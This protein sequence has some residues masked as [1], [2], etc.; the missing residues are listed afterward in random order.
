MVKLLRILLALAFI[1]L[2]ALRFSPCEIFAQDK[3]IAIVNTDVITQKDLNDFINFMRMQ[4][5]RD[6]KQ[7]DVEK[8]I[9]GMKLD[10]LTRLIEDR[11]IL[12][13]A[14]KEG[15][16]VDEARVKA[17]LDEIRQHYATDADFQK[18]LVRQ[19]LV[20]SDLES[21]IREQLLM[22]YIVELKIRDKVIVRPD[23]VTQLYNSNTKDFISPEER[24]L[25]VIALER[26]DL[27]K[28]FSFDYRT[29]KKLEELATR[30]PVIVNKMIISRE[31]GLRKEIADRV[32]S[33]NIGE[34]SDALKIEDKYYVFKLENI[35]PARQKTLAESQDQIHSFLFQRKM[36]ERLA[37][38]IDELKSK[39]YIK[40]LQN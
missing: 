23:E 40:I 17:R 11:L 1:A 2:C 15:I 22:Y 34:I 10:L 33:L 18:D 28:A 24:E 31:E 12:Q 14:K 30:Y 7:Q 3:I 37:K 39:S 19:G 38:W 8:K 13:E 35:I 20:Q 4:L 6:N 21:K 9:D 25:E 5:S 32:F 29:G 26:E 16:K 36:Q 27:A